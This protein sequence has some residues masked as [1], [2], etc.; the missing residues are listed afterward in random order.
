MQKSFVDTNIWIYAFLESSENHLRQK[1][2]GFL[3]KLIQEDKTN[4]N[5]L[6]FFFFIA[7]IFQIG[8]F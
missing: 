5:K 8:F 1:S 4:L 2:L 7:P 6:A 3:E